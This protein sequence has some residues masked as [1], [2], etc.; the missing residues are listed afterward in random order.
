MS[1]KMRQFRLLIAFSLSFAVKTSALAQNQRGYLQAFNYL[2]KNHKGK[3]LVTVDTLIQAN[4]SSFYKE[5]S[6]DWKQRPST[7]IKILDSLDYSSK[8]YFKAVVTLVRLNVT[9]TKPEYLI[10]FSSIKKHLL[11]AE[12][13]TRKAGYSLAYNE[14]TYFNHGERYL[15][16][17][18]RHLRIKSIYKKVIQYN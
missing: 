11:V 12:I 4:F 9:G 2:Q 3:Q 14:Q 5:L 17:L 7:T 15:F 10:Y 6:K 1:S 18:D 16:V 13:I 8:E